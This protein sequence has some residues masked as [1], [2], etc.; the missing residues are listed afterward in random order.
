MNP[1]SDGINLISILVYIFSVQ[2]DSCVNIFRLIKYFSSSNQIL[3]DVPKSR[4]EL[5]L[6]WRTCSHTNIVNLKDVYENIFMGHRSLLVVMEWWVWL[7]CNVLSNHSVR[8][9]RISHD[10]D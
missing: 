2:S 5:D 1:L 3:R 6:H 9:K 8:G 10:V 7:T 4:R